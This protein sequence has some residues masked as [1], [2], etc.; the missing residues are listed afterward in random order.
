[1][2]AT[3]AARWQSYLRDCSQLL[4]IADPLQ[5]AGRVTRVTGLVLQAAGLRLPIGAACRVPAA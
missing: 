1:M 4:Q 3:N 2:N 5:V